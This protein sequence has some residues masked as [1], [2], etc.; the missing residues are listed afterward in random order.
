VPDRLHWLGHVAAMGT[1]FLALLGFLACIG[2][3]AQQI[4]ERFPFG[5]GEE[6]TLLPSFNLEAL[7]VSR[8]DRCRNPCAN[9]ALTSQM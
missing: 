1:I 5:S 9:V 2:I 3:A 4:V 7:V 6:G 8:P